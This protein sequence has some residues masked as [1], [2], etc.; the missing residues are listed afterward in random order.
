MGSVTGGCAKTAP[1]QRQPAQMRLGV[2]FKRLKAG[3]RLRPGDALSRMNVGHHRLCA[4]AHVQLLEYLC[5]VVFHRERTDVELGAY[6][7]VRQAPGQQV[8]NL[9]LARTRSEERRVGKECRSRW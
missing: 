7:L 3:C 6:F 9:A 4:A 8:K 5:Q 2:S 1:A